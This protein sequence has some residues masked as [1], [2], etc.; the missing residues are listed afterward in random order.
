MNE[1]DMLSLR[2]DKL[3][4]SNASVEAV[5]IEFLA[6]SNGRA[7]SSS[8][9]LSYRIEF[10]LGSNGSSVVFLALLLLSLMLLSS[11]P[12][13]DSIVSNSGVNVRAAAEEGV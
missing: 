9:D 4:G 11:D 8:N 1:L 5:R 2:I 3:F 13:A 10:F 7:S 12:G 6:G